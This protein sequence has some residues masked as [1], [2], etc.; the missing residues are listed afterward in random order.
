MSWC[1]LPPPPSH[2]SYKPMNIRLEKFSSM[3]KK[4]LAPILLN[5]QMPATSV[6]VNSVK[7]SPDL[8]IAHIYLSVWGK[9][10]KLV[11]DGIDAS[12]GEISRLLAT[13]LRSK[14]SPSLSFHM[15]NGQDDS[16]RIAELLKS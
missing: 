6:S 5:Y 8:K 10:A 14:F 7:I 16:Q 9:H 4:Q 1:L 11:F 3:V 15:D 12:H 2:A 13:K